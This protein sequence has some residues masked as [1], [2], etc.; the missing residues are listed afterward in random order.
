MVVTLVVTLMEITMMI[1][2]MMITTTMRREEGGE[3][4]MRKGGVTRGTGSS[5]RGPNTTGWLGK[6]LFRSSPAAAVVAADALPDE[7]EEGADGE[8]VADF[9]FDGLHGRAAGGGGG[10]GEVCQVKHF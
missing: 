4:E 1:M 10:V 7:V 9:E 6:T 5:Q 3:E 2:M 8:V